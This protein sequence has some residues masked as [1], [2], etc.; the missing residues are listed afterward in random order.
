MSDQRW[1]VIVEQL[2]A[3]GDDP[4]VWALSLYRRQGLR[5]RSVATYPEFYTTHYAALSTARD[6]ISK[7]R[8]QEGTER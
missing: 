2:E 8:R 1:R 6:W 3:S 5:W 4:S 7:V